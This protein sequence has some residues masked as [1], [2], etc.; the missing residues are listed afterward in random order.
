MQAKIL[1][2]EVYGIAWLMPPYLALPY[3]YK[4]LEE[5]KSITLHSDIA[6]QQHFPSAN[7]LYT[8]WFPTTDR[9]SSTAVS[10][11][12]SILF[13][14]ISMLSPD[15]RDQVEALTSQLM[16]ADIALSDSLDELYHRLSACSWTMVGLNPV[17]DFSGGASSTLYQGANLDRALLYSLLC[18]W[19]S[20]PEDEET[21]AELITQANNTIWSNSLAYLGLDF[22]NLQLLSVL[23]PPFMVITDID[24]PALYAGSEGTLTVT[25][26]NKGDETAS[27]VTATLLT[28]DRETTGTSSEITV[29]QIGKD[30][31]KTVSW[32]VS[33]IGFE[34]QD[35][36]YFQILLEGEDLLAKEETFFIVVK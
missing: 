21:R 6:L 33:A 2:Q 4:D 3:V 32:E 24:K 9:I 34:H 26:K 20:D 36:V 28:S 5:I 23:A 12:N 18:I 27:G 31:E 22:S 1:S 30:E 25:L 10:G 13:Q 35:V 19:L 15:N 14:I 16:E 8:L 11:Y 17:L 29:G 7:T